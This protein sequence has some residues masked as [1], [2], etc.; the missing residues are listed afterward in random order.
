MEIISTNKTEHHEEVIGHHTNLYLNMIAPYH[1]EK[2]NYAEALRK[3]TDIVIERKK[4]LKE[5]I[6]ES[7]FMKVIKFLFVR[8]K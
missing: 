7:G 1:E 6:K 4:N 8:R 5:P 3:G 2:S